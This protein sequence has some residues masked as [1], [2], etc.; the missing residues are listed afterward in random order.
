MDITTE[1]P[2]LCQESH[3]GVEHGKT[4]KRRGKKHAVICCLRETCS[5]RQSWE[6]KR[7]FAFP[8]PTNNNLSVL[9]S[10]ED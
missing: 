5:L 6:D 8:K 2:P 10:D 4:Q 3:T 7:G 1:L 9:N